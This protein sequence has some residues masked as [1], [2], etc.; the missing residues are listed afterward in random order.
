MD[1]VT[2]LAFDMDGEAALTTRTNG[3]RLVVIAFCAAIRNWARS[4]VYLLLQVFGTHDLLSFMARMSIRL[5][6]V[7][8]SLSCYNCI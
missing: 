5:N 1:R 2:G 7:D 8:K 6:W 3:S 4:N